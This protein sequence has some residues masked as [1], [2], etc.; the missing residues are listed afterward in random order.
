MKKIVF[1]ALL[2]GAISSTAMADT[3]PS[4]DLVQALMSAGYPLPL[5][6]PVGLTLQVTQIGC[7]KSGGMP[8][9]TV[10]NCYLFGLTTQIKA[11]WLAALS[12]YQDLGMLGATGA[13][14]NPGDVYLTARDVSCF[15]DARPNAGNSQWAC[16]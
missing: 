4:A 2:I 8:T 6:T 16:T 12:I 3:N 5:V 10:I 13:V 14:Q 7:V 15:K 9:G 1:Y 11:I